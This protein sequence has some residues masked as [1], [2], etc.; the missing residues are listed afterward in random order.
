VRDLLQPVPPTAAKTLSTDPT[1]AEEGAQYIA[2]TA[3]AAVS[4]AAMTLF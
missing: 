3:A 4:M 1:R 2:L